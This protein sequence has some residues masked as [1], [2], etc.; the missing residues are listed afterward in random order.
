M[1]FFGNF[2]INQKMEPIAKVT[3]S[4]PHCKKESVFQLYRDYD[5]FELFFI[6]VAKFHK[7]YQA[8]CCNCSSLF[9]LD[10]AVGNA[11]R[12]GHF[13]AIEVRHLR[14]LTEPDKDFC[15]RCGHPLQNDFLYCPQCGCSV[16]AP[17][18]PAKE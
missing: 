3:L 17:P 4:C 10:P 9:A 14:S 13:V 18:S 15:P 7:H 1:F 2:G 8:L 5:S 6:P 12:Q 16:G 11:W